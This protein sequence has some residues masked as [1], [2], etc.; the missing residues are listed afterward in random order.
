MKYERSEEGSGGQS[1]MLCFFIYIKKKK[2]VFIEL[3][4]SYGGLIWVRPIWD[5]VNEY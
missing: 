4:N 3:R 2:K 5:W 1:V